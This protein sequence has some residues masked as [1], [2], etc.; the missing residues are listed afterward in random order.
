MAKRKKRFDCVKM[1]TAIQEQLIR[2][3]ELRKDEFETVFDYII[4]SAKEKK[5]CQETLRKSAAR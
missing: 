1:K 2:E 4:A 5:W 3:Y